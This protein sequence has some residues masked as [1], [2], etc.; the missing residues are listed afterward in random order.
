MKWVFKT[1]LKENGKVDNYK[2][3]L[4]AKVYKQEYEIDYK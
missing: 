4:V 1:K 2:A 3:R